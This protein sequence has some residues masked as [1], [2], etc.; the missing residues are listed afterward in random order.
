MAKANIYK[1]RETLFTKLA[2]LMM[3]TG[4]AIGILS[5]NNSKLFGLRYTFFLFSPGRTFLNSL[6]HGIYILVQKKSIKFADFAKKSHMCNR[7]FPS[8]ELKP[9]EQCYKSK[10]IKRVLEL[11]FLTH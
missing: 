2:V 6:Q 1:K 3:F 9:I 11:N 7:H 5:F 10:L 4:H 8:K